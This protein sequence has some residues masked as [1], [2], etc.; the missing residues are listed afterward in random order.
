M[1]VAS[2]TIKKAAGDALKNNIIKSFVVCVSVLLCYLINYN[3]SSC[4]YFLGGNTFANIFFIIINL[5]MFSPIIFGAI[6]YFWRMLCGVCDNPVSVFYY[7]TSKQNY[8]K[9]IKITL[10]LAVKAAI[11]AVLFF[12]PFFAVSVISNVKIYEFLDITIPLW[13]A[14][15]SNLSVFL[16]SIGTIATIFAMLKFYLVPM[17]IVADENMDVNEA[18]HMS[19]VISK[20]TTLEFIFLVFSMLGW[21]L[22]SLLFIPLLYTIPFFITVYLTHCSFAVSEYNEHIKNLNS[23]AFPSFMAGI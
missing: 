16:R 18:M 20:R 5:F 21:I 19:A 9:S 17:L 3:I 10:R 22:L 12:V 15:L 2:S 4:L 8:L 11:Y 1:T 14:N 7:F 13:T 23:Q 6:R